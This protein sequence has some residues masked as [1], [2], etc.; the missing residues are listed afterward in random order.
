[1]SFGNIPEVLPK[2]Y[3]DKINIVPGACWEW[4]AHRNQKGYG[5]VGVGGKLKSVHRV[6]Y[7]HLHGPIPNGLFVLHKCDHPPCVNPDHLRLGTPAEN[8]RDMVEKHRSSTL[9]TPEQ[10]AEAK[11][12]FQKGVR[13]MHVAKAFG[14]NHWII[15]SLKR[16]M[17]RQ[18]AAAL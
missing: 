5:R 8:S 9:L 14:V 13:P 6:M 3:W 12:L 17:S 15:Y 4:T 11:D 16:N 18:Q 2:R 1:M 7:E 10:I